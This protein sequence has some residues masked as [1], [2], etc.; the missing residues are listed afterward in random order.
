M[1][2]IVDSDGFI[3]SLNPVNYHHQSS[4]KIF[5]KLIAERYK[6]IYPSTTVVETVIFLQGRLNSPFLADQVIKLINSNQLIIEPVDDK[7]LQD[8]TTY[9]NLKSSKHHTLFDA[10]I[11]AIAKK[12]K[13]DAIFSFDKFYK[14]QGFKLA[15]DL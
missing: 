2:I 6:L 13:A 14:K 5:Q 4:H 11:A 15:S 12:Y 7:I 9:M 8:A 3:G 1:I 10:V